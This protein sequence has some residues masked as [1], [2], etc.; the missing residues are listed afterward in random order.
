MSNALFMD[1]A[2]TSEELV[3]IGDGVGTSRH[4]EQVALIDTT[5]LIEVSPADSERNHWAYTPDER[6]QIIRSLF[7]A[8]NA[9]WVGRFSF[10]LAMSVV[11]ATLGLANDQPAAVIQ[12]CWRSGQ[13]S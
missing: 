5:A 13:S 7:L 3:R 2:L 8:D 12:R 10:L 6:V 11:T 4:S 9:P 1:N